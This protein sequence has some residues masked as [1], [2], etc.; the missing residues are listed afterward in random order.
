MKYYVERNFILYRDHNS[1][2][3]QNIDYSS[4]VR[5]QQFG[6]GRSP[7]Q[8]PP[9]GVGRQ[10]LGA[11]PSFTPEL[12]SSERQQFQEPLRFGPDQRGGRFPGQS[13]RRRRPRDL[14]NCIN[15]FT[16]IWL[17]NGNNFWF[18]PIFIAGQQVIGFRW[19]RGVWVYD[20]ISINRIF[21]HQCF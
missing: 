21:F 12:P 2:K 15:R 7:G 14:R 17:V 19:R 9:L 1:K 3:I 4:P 11:P 20:R 18:Y 6:P 10:P 8:Q 16:Y 5:N 13:D